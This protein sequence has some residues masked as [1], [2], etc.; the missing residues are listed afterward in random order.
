M[1]ACSLTVGGRTYD[2]DAVGLL[3]EALGRCLT[4]GPGGLKVS[5][6][7]GAAGVLAEVVREMARHVRLELDPESDPELVDYLMA[8]G[9]G[10]SVGALAGAAAS[11]VA[12]AALRQAALRLLGAAAPSLAAVVLVGSALTS[13]VGSFS[14]LMMARARLRL[15]FV[16]TAG[17]PAAVELALQPVTP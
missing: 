12:Y 8:A 15:R 13:L 6:P 11:A 16:S 2:F 4:A 10:G 9:L 7:A 1:S 3:V 5:V 17:G 14:G